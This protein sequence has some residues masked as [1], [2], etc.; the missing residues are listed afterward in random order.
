[1][2]KKRLIFTLLYSRGHF[3]LS[4]N[5]R[6]QKVGDFNWLQR[7]YDFSHI[8][9]S[10]DE[11]VVL[12]VDRD[13][14][15]QKEFCDVLK[16]LAKGCFAPIAAGGAVR[17][18]DD[19]RALLRSGADKIVLNTPL[20]E[21]PELVRALAAEFGQQCIVGSVDVKRSESKGY[22]VFSSCGALEIEADLS[23]WIDQISAESV[24][25]IYLN[26][27]D[28]DGTGQGY[29][30]GILDSLSRKI[31]VPVIFAGGVGNT[32]HLAAG[33]ADSRIDAVATANLFNFVGDGL[34]KA[35]RTLVDSGV[36]LPL[37]NIEL[38][39]RHFASL[40][41]VAQ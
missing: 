31:G 1:M 29:D 18:I 19:A 7:N 36:N 9:Y 26:S 8:A 23:G 35:R 11:L 16:L 34:K 39:E 10:I 21:S 5:F 41:K 2:L 22:A 40:R 28:R 3:M 38:M 15:C 12:N 13:G 14:A 24:G 25:E 20:Y 6:L 27:I 17:S 37:W 33:L 4:R 32:A 30:F